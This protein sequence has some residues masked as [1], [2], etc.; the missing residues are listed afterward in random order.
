VLN[1]R[2]PRSCRL[3]GPYLT[4]FA[5]QSVIRTV[6]EAIEAIEL[7][8]AQEKMEDVKTALVLAKETLQARIDALEE[9]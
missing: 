6:N 9:A 1:L 3:P 7:A 4:K 2:T 5:L 8:E